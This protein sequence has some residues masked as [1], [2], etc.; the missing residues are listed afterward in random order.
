MKQFILIL[1]GVVLT[2]NLSAQ[3]IINKQFALID[4]NLEITDNFGDHG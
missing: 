3:N 1:T 4:Y 2:L